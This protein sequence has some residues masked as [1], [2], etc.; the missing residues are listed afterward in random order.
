M[1]TSLRTVKS[2]PEFLR[3]AQKAFC[4]CKAL[5]SVTIQTGRLTS[6]SS[7]KYIFTRAGQ[8]NYKN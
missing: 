4:D 5:T 7:G 6:K 8:N 2:V 1:H 3:S